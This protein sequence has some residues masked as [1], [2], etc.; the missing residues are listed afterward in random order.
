MFFEHFRLENKIIDVF[1][2]FSKPA[3]YVTVTY[4]FTEPNRL[5]RIESNLL[6]CMGAFCGLSLPG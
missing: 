3:V 2:L 6:M 5:L 4:V 1:M